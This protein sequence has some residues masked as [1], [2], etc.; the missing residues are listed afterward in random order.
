MAD[1]VDRA[2]VT[3]GGPTLVRTAEG[4]DGPI[5]I[6]KLS[7]GPLDNNAYVL[8]DVASG[9]ALLVDAANE[10]ERLLRE[11]EGRDLVG[12]LTTHGHQDH[13]QALFDVAGATG[14]PTL[15]H[16]DDAGLVPR[17]ADRHVA[18]GEELRVGGFAV[19][20]L[21]TPGHTPGSVCVLLEAPAER[22]GIAR[23]L[24]TGDTLFPG[25][26]GATF[27]DEEA[28][29]QLM[30]TLRQRVFTLDDDTQVCPGHGDDTTLGAERADL[31]AWE[32]RG[33]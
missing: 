10:A 30:T 20:L 29:A 17:G 1:D 27:G 15:L 25:G 9:K 4:P 11:V 6:R 26:P 23:W 12:I 28:F 2:H 8:T 16:P 33:W 19:R 13:W 32:A 7:V 14:A 22:G 3:P 31:D 18:D 24:F 5:E 21:H